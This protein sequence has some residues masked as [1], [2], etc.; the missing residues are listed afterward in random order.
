MGWDAH[1]EWGKLS[2]AEKATWAE[3][4]RVKNEDI[5]LEKEE[6]Q[7]YENRGCFKSAF[8]GFLFWYLFG[9]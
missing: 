9:L 1:V 8:S 5:R 4:A 3:I 7:N 6:V 2:A